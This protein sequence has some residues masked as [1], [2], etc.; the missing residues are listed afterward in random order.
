M[1]GV[2]WPLQVDTIPEAGGGEQAHGFNWILFFIYNHIVTML[3]CETELKLKQ[4]QPEDAFQA[5]CESEKTWRVLEMAQVPSEQPWSLPK[6]DGQLPSSQ[7]TSK[8]RRG[9]ESCS[10][11]KLKR[12]PAWSCGLWRALTSSSL[13]CVLVGAGLSGSSTIRQCWCRSPSSAIKSAGVQIQEQLACAP[14]QP[15]YRLLCACI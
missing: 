13:A 9:E 6:Q 7:T 3:G 8:T 4:G 2:S 15:C 1:T 12:G 10:K 5:E 14:L 11:R